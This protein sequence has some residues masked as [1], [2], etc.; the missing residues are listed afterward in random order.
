MH[1]A[2]VPVAELL[3]D[4]EVRRTRRTGPGGQH[5]NKVETAVVLRHGPTGILAEASERRSQEENR[6]MAL[7]RLR[8]ALA[9]AHRTP[10]AAEPSRL[11]RSRVRQRRLAVS[12]DHDDYPA[13][14]A[15]AFDV[16][17][18]HGADVP[19]AAGH[20]GVSA[21]QLVKLFRKSPEAWTALN[22]L[23]GAAGRPP[24]A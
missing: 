5:R 20:L 2:A 16:L 8:L 12:V 23:R 18:G 11:W 9:V 6:R 21:S 19:A 3:R 14:V 1:P 10:P 17:Q 4:V 7:R 15:E 24:L 13:L 22:R